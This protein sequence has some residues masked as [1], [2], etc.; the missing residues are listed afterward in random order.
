MKKFGL[1]IVVPLVLLCGSDV[2]KAKELVSPVV[3]ETKIQ[4]DVENFVQNLG[5]KAIEIINKPGISKGQVQ[6]EFKELLQNHFALRDIARYSL[7]NFYR[8][9]SK[10][11]EQDFLRCFENMLVKV[12]SSNFSAY[13]TAKLVVT[14]GKIKTTKKGKQQILVY[15]NVVVPNKADVNVTWSVFS[16]EGRNHKVYDVI[17]DN[18]SISSSQ[19]SEFRGSIVKNSL[20]KFLEK[21]KKDHSKIEGEV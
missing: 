7:G 18:V 8:E 11:E 17:I 6:K 10:E 3:E 9:L 2:V 15:S 1:W 16:T 13:K 19:R 14:G 5:N 21:F 4:K 12:Y 20:K